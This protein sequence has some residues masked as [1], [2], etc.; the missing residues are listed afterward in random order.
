M[1]IFNEKVFQP[2]YKNKIQIILSVWQ[3]LS[4]L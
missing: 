2:E 4:I 1:I 3:P